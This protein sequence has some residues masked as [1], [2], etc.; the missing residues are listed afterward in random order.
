MGTLRVLFALTLGMA[1]TGKLYAQSEE[2]S[3]K[4]RAFESGEE[5]TYTVAYNWFIIWTEVGEVTF[6]VNETTIFN[7]PCLHLA[8][9]GTTYSSWDWFFKVRDRYESWVHPV[10]LKPYFFIRDVNEGGYKFRYK[11]IFNRTKG[12]ALT[13]YTR[14]GKPEKMDT[15]DITECTFDM[16]SISYYS[17]NIDYTRYKPGD[18]IPVTILLDNIL[19][20]IYFRYQGI[21]NI[22]I[23]RF[24]EFEC[25]KFSVFLVAGSVFK[26][27]EYMSIWVT[28]DKNRIPLY[29]ES[30][31]II[32]SIKARITSIEGNKYALTS[33]IR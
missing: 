26:G 9:K 11:Y 14:P 17:R 4:N 15:V 29:A 22:K 20:N 16:I 12:Y 8:G 27:G 21:E 31:I 32:G 19:E 10:T 13:S 30:P 33:K 3:I 5:I 2:C 28:N 18:T 6:R 23:R 25:I 24:G 7:E 1:A